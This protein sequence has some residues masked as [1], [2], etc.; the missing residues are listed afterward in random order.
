MSINLRKR[1]NAADH[2][3]QSCNKKMR[4]SK[5][6][7]QLHSISHLP[8]E[9]RGQ[10]NKLPSETLVTIF[11]H[12]DVASRMSIEVL[13]SLMV[14]CAKYVTDV[15]FGELGNYTNFANCWYIVLEKIPCDQLEHIDMSGIEIYDHHLNFL[16]RRFRTLKSATFKRCFSTNLPCDQGIIQNVK[17]H[18]RRFLLLKRIDAFDAMI[19]YRM[20]FF[21]ALQFLRRSW[22]DV[23]QEAIAICFKKAGFIKHVEVVILS[24]ILCTVKIFSRLIQPTES[25]EDAD[26][27]YNELMA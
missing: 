25:A 14:R 7:S 23:K 6:L 8:K 1:L 26:A 13:S 10:I 21:K 22:S 15:D 9:N 2:M 5:V 11:E 17:V 27:M 18:Y 4:Y 12:L 20:D 24:S 16:A 19:D 3:D